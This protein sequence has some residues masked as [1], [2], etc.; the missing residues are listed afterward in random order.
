ML[1]KLA[2][3]LA[4]SQGFEPMGPEESLTRTANIE[5]TCRVWSVQG[6]GRALSFTVRQDFGLTKSTDAMM[7]NLQTNPGIPDAVRQLA[8]RIQANAGEPSRFN[9]FER[10]AFKLTGHRDFRNVGEIPREEGTLTFHTCQNKQGERLIYGIEPE[11]KQREGT[12]FYLPIDAF[13]LLL[14]RLEALARA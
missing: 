5:V 14:P 10:M 4:R 12:T 9:W 3:K 2:E 7:L 13:A 6:H 8:E 11:T 1:E